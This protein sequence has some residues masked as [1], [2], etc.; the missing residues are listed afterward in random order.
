MVLTHLPANLLLASIA[1]APNLTTAI[2]LL[3]ARFAL[4]QMDVPTRQAYV[5]GVVDESE[6]TA[7]TAYTNAARYAVRPFAPLVAGAL[8]GSSLGAPFLIAGALKSCYDLG[9]YALF[10]NVSLTS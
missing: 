6:R 3:L 1:F 5:V 8:V 9:L 4:S 7:A 10:R 2:A